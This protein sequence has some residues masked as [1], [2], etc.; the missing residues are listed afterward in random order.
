MYILKNIFK[1]LAAIY[2]PSKS[3]ETARQIIFVFVVHW[4]QLGLRSKDEY[5]TIVQNV[6]FYFLLYTPIYVKLLRTYHPLF[7]PAYFSSEQK[8]CYM[9]LGVIVQT[10]AGRYD[11][12]SIS[13]YFSKLCN[14]ILFDFFSIAWY[15]NCIHCK[16]Y[17]SC[18]IVDSK[19]LII[20]LNS[21]LST[22][23]IGTM[24]LAI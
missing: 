13:Q 4:R 17:C 1:A 8:F 5:E 12:N 3:I 24:S 11:Q 14:F 16:N 15:V 9:R 18:S 22:V 10:S 7:E 6:I 19:R 21:S 20:A 23:R 2:S